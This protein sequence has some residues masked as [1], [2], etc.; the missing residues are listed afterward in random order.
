MADVGTGT[1]ITFGTSGFDANLLSIDGPSS[2][3]ESVETS[4]MGTTGDHT[5][6][7]ADLVDRGEVSLTFEFDPDK[8]PPIDQAAETITITWP[9]PSG[10]SNG[11]TW[12]FTG[13]MTDYS[14]GA[15][16]DERMEASATIKI[17]GDINFTDA[18]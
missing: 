14:P 8:E 4:H 12:Q 2:T 17:S 3:R 11:A 6:M 5:F 1:S 15:A 13:F 18:S 16:I 10:S 9:V 7:P